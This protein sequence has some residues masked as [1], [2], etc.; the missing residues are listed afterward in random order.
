MSPRPGGGRPGE[1]R[2]RV[3]MAVSHGLARDTRVRKTARSVAELGYQVTL[4]WAFRD[5]AADETRA[6]GAAD[7]G[8]PS[9]TGVLRGRLGA[10]ETI[11]VP[12][13]YLLQD[14]WRAREPRAS[15]PPAG[16]G[17]GWWPYRGEAARA[18]RAAVL[19]LRAARLAAGQPALRAAEAIHR[20]RANDLARRQ[21]R[22]GR[23]FE[24]ARSR[25]PWRA[26]AH[27]TSL[28]AALTP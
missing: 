14:Y 24:R 5:I 7:A 6:A 27:V 15:E 4:L 26:L 10:V 13:D 1:A 17:L 8:G 20:R 23:R 21:W 11:G 9:R 25:R 3:A 2:P 12:V 16:P 22:R 18:E 28:E 19:A